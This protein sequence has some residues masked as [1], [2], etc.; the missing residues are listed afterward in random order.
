MIIE[1]IFLPFKLLIELIISALPANF[2]NLDTIPENLASMLY[3]GF[4]FFPQDVATLI[5]SSVI[6]WATANFIMSLFKF[7]RG[8]K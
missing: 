3:V 2:V 5:L 7:I 6:F 1:A 8:S 4:Q